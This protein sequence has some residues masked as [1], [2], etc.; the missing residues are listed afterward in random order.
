MSNGRPFYS[1][2]ARDLPSLLHYLEV[3]VPGMG[4]VNRGKG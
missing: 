4:Q 1:T 3:F 2:S